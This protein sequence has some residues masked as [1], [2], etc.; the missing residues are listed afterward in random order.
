MLVIFFTYCALSLFWSD[1]PFVAFKRL[2]KDLGNVVMV[3]IILTD[4]DPVRATKFVIRRCAYVMIPFSI[5]LYKYFPGIGRTWGRWLGEEM[6]TGV[7]AQKNSLGILCAV[8]GLFF[9]WNLVTDLRRMRMGR[10]KTELAL[11][12]LFLI[13]TMWLLNKTNSATSLICFGT[14]SAII[15]AMQTSVVRAKSSQLGLYLFLAVAS[16]IIMDRLF[17]ITELI[18]TGLGRNMTFTERTDMWEQ[19]TSMV[20]SPLIGVGY[21][22]FWLG[23]RLARMGEWA[24][25]WQPMEAHDGYLETYLEL[26]YIGVAILS[27]LIIAAYVKIG[28]EIRRNYNVGCLK[29]AMLSTVLLYNFSETSFKGINICWFLFLLISIEYVSPE[30]YRASNL[31]AG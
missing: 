10:H 4:D 8:I 21:D 23:S 22:S 6:I 25:W 11:N 20:S 1:Y 28:R 7:T 15:L 16:Y 24:R 13:M 3:M 12:I 2:I 5:M 14:G 29:L 19:V 30:R 9:L 31:R 26:G 17:G 27:A 18:V